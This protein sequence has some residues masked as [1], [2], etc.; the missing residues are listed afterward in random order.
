MENIA[1]IKEMWKHATFD[2]YI[3]G[4]EAFLMLQSIEKEQSCVIALLY[5][6]GIAEG[7]RIERA[8]RKR[9]CTDA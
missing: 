9:R 7:K 6:A 8:K 5:L 3:K 2:D 4:R 1:E